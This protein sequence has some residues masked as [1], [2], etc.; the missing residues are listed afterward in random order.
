MTPW[1]L[2]R[3]RPSL[4]DATYFG[5]VHGGES[6]TAPIFFDVLDAIATE[7]A[8][9]PYV[10]HLLTNG[11]LLGEKTARRLLDLG[12]SS[13]SVSLDG[14]TAATNDAVRLGGRFDMIVDNLRR[15]AQLRRDEGRDLRLGVSFVILDGNLHEIP[16]L[17]DLAANIGVDWVKLEEAVPVNA[18]AARSLVARPPGVVQAAVADAIVRGRERGL[19]VVDHTIDRTIWRCRLDAEPDTAE[20]VRA[21]EFANRSEIHPCRAPWEVLCVEPNGDVRGGHFFGPILGNV[22]GEELAAI[23]NGPRAREER[24]RS[25]ARR[26]CGPDGPVTCVP[27]RRRGGA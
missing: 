21:D 23:W 13:I 24:A 12:V 9:Q 22:T 18:F 16:A 5:F 20:F 25:I 1:I 14:A 17:V 7:R 11:V 15:V 19:V 27:E 26:V 10:A 4:G 8:G 3:L 6:L 2:E